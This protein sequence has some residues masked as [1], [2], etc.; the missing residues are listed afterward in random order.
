MV[1]AGGVAQVFA[2]TRPGPK[3]ERT[4][5]DVHVLPV[6]QAKVTGT[7]T[8]L[9]G[10]DVTGPPLR[11]PIAVDHGTVTV[12]A[13]GDT[14]VWQGGRPFSLTGGGVDLG[15]TAVTI[16]G[17]GAHW[18]LDG[19]HLLLP[20]DYVL[21]APVAVGSGG[22]AEPRD[23]YR[24]TARADATIEVADATVTTPVTA[25]HLEGPGRL[26]LDGTFLV[27][28]RAGVRRATHLEFGPGS[29]TLDLRGH[30]LTA[31][32]QGPLRG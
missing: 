27:E 17:A 29:F 31:T 25:L 18:P 23:S 10:E 16:D 3:V 8:A 1:F 2:D 30:D 11:T 14:I 7:L 9:R 5:R 6:D 26:V 13:N 28:T 15:P 19:E 12:R 20:G 21:D 32:L 22:L 4:V 24:F